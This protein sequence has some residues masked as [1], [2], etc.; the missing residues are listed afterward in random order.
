MEGIKLPVQF[1]RKLATSLGKQLA[2]SDERV[3]FCTKL[4]MVARVVVQYS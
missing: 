2:G 1:G 3:Y 4:L